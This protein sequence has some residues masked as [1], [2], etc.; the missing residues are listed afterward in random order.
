VAELKNFY[1]ELGL[2]DAYISSLRLPKFKEETKLVLIEVGPDG[3]EKLLASTAAQSWA[4]LKSK[5]HSDGV[6]LFTYSAFRSFELQYELIKE[7]LR[8]GESLEQVLQRLAAPGFSEHH[9]GRAV[10][11]TCPTFP[12]PTQEFDQSIEFN[13][14]TEN[15]SEFKFSLSYPKGNTTGIM[16]E[17]WHWCFRGVLENK[18]L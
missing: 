8:K 15:A 1:N 10:D 7:R 16:Y 4:A 9:T 12:H 17:P 2:T 6:T 18:E 3:K 14:L 11:V 5:A 13:W